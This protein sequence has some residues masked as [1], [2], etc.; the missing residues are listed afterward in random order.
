MATKF[1]KVSKTHTFN[2]NSTIIEKE[3]YPEPALFL[4]LK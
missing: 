3:G 2:S 4:V 1:K